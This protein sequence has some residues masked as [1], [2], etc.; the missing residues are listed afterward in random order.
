ML[1]CGVSQF[2]AVMLNVV[3][4]TVVMYHYRSVLQSV[5]APGGPSGVG[6]RKFKSMLLNARS[7]KFLKVNLKHYHIISIS[8]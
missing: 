6:G 3:R 4:P 2:L 5:V 7:K 8:A 1:L